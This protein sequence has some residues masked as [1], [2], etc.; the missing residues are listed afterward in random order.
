M[1]NITQARDAVTSATARGW[2]NVSRSPGIVTLLAPSSRVDHP[3][4]E[5]VKRNGWWPQDTY[6]LYKH[7]T[8]VGKTGFVRT[9][10]PWTSAREEKVSLKKLIEVL[11]SE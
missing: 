9:A 1:A 8:L 7:V 11:E 3:T 4:P 5:H 2:E 10:I 6:H